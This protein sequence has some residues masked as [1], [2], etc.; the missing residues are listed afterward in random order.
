MNAAGN[1]RCWGLGGSGQLLSGAVANIGRAAND[2]VGLGNINFGTGLT[3]TSFS[4]GFFTN[5]LVISDKHVKCFGIATSGALCSGG[6][7]NNLGD[8]AG[9]LGAGLPNINH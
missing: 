6:I 2:I 5:C 9:E 4:M 8:V 7:A 3:A 1:V